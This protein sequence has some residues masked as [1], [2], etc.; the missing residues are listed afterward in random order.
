MWYTHIPYTVCIEGD[1]LTHKA[2]PR[3]EVHIRECGNRER[4]IHRM[5]NT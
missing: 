3:E 4:T 2:M 1:R 5:E